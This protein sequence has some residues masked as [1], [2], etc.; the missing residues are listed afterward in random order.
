MELDILLRQFVE[1][2]YETLSCTQMRLLHKML[3]LEDLELLEMVR[4]PRNAG[5]YSEVIETI[6]NHQQ[7]IRSKS[8][9]RN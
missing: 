9:D 2:R 7:E 8:Q 5:I 6:L 3:S 1:D 4:N